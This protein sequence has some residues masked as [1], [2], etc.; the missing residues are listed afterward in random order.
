MDK[1]RLLQSLAS[2]PL[3]LSLPAR[4]Q[5]RDYPQRPIRLVSPFAAGSDCVT[6]GICGAGILNAF[7]GTRR[8]AGTGG[9]AGKSSR[10]PLR[11]EPLEDR[12]LQ[13]TA[14]LQVN[15]LLAVDVTGMTVRQA[16]EWVTTMK[17]TGSRLAIWLSTRI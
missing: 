11:L 12:R 17:L 8:A 14:L 2:L 1:R 9:T 10:S 15:G 4:A 3:A 13:A 16:Y 7:G 6:R 5:A